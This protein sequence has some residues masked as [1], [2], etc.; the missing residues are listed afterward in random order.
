MTKYQSC[1]FVNGNGEE[2]YQILEKGWIFYHYP[3]FFSDWCISL[4]KTTR[5]EPNESDLPAQ[6]HCTTSQEHIRPSP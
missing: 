4:L 3:R 6:D 1:K 5:R 2:W